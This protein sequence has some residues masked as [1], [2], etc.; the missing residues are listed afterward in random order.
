MVACNSSNLIAAHI[1]SLLAF[2]LALMTKMSTA[3]RESK[4]LIFVFK[5]SALKEPNS[6]YR[7]E[8]FNLTNSTIVNDLWQLHLRAAHDTQ[9]KLSIRRVKN[10]LLVQITFV[11]ASIELANGTKVR[12]HGDHSRQDTAIC[13]FDNALLQRLLGGDEHQELKL[14]VNIMYHYETAPRM[15]VEFYDHLKQNAIRATKSQL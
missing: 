1:S 5:A 4:E 13:Y 2:V 9:A 10:D 14:R 3:I 7:S 12:G 6:W 15:V 11:D 8:L